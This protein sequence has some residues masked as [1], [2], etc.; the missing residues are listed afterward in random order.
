M[1]LQQH[2]SRIWHANTPT[3]HEC[4]QGNAGVRDV[5]LTAVAVVQQ[6]AEPNDAGVLAALQKFQAG[7]ELP[8]DEKLRSAVVEA[9][10]SIAVA[11][12]ADCDSH[13]DTRTHT[14]A[15]R[16][17]VASCSSSEESTSESEYEP[18][19]NRRRVHVAGAVAAA[20]DAPPRPALPARSGQ[21][22]PDW[23]GVPDGADGR[24]ANS[25]GDAVRWHLRPRG[26]GHESEQDADDPGLVAGG[27][28]REWVVECRGNAD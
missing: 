17:S 28:A 9:C 14:R 4:D 3:P 13:L 26:G 7:L 23:S 8:A 16:R 22:H 19:E 20:L 11:Q 25:G 10:Q 27:F 15:W 12:P 2:A 6:L 18:A 1:A 21:A 24:H 5:K